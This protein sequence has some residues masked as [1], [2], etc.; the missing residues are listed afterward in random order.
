MPAFILESIGI[1]EI[2]LVLLVFAY[3]SGFIIF[4][5]FFAKVMRKNFN[6]QS[7]LKKCPYCAEMIQPEA[8]IC[9]YCKRDL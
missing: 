6:I 4:V 5:I 1:G 3:V 9:R 7:T 2:I 8:V